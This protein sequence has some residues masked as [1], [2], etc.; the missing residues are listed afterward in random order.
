MLIG[1]RAASHGGDMHAAFMCERRLA[2]KRQMFI[3]CD[4]GN[5]RN[6]MRKIIQLADISLG[7]TFIAHLK[8]KVSHDGNEVGIAAAFTDTIDRSLHLNCGL[9]APLSTN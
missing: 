8:F 5:F 6:E 7:Q 1:L 9:H 4:V 2:H 3:G